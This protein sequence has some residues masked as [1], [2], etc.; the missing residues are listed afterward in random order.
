MDEQ[1]HRNSENR[2][3]SVDG[4]NNEPVKQPEQEPEQ[5][6]Y[7]PQSHKPTVV[8]IKKRRPLLHLFLM[9][10]LVG[11]TTGVG[12]MWYQTDKQLQIE[13]AKAATIQSQ[14]NTD[15]AFDNPENVDTGALP[16]NFAS[17]LD[18]YNNFI[19]S[20]ITNPVEEEV[21]EAEILS[22]VAKY[23]EIEEVT[24]GTAVLVVYQVVKPD[25][26]PTGDISA[27]VYIPSSEEKPAGFVDVLK[28]SGGEW[29][30]Y[31]DGL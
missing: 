5:H 6:E 20:T 11:A 23:Y 7:N 18:E 26:D 14:D 19:Q 31:I 30:V 2:S 25:T 12:Y 29:A 9:V 1:E 10:L 15:A 3:E 17:F 27:L 4:S 16:P 8:H 21:D 22:A 13:R 28:K 24:E